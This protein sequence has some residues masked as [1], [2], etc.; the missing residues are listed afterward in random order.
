MGAAAG[1]GCST[2][3]AGGVHINPLW[4]ITPPRSRS[5]R[6]QRRSICDLIWYS[7]YNISQHLFILAP[8]GTVGISSAPF[9]NKK[10]LQLKPPLILTLLLVSE[11]LTLEVVIGCVTEWILRH[12]PKGCSAHMSLQHTNNIYTET[13]FYFYK[14]QIIVLLLLMYSFVSSIYM[15]QLV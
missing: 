13:L 12:T 5:L 11:V 7:L 2:G 14:Y 1:G 4:D 9:L 3:S 10:Q 15:L 8:D 6:E